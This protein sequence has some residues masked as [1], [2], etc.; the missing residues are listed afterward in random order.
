MATPELAIDYLGVH[1]QVLWN[2]RL[3]RE[4]PEVEKD[5]RRLYRKAG[6]RNL[7]RYEAVLDWLPGGG[8]RPPWYWTRLWASAIGERVAD[9]PEAV[10]ELVERME[11]DPIVKGRPF[12]FRTWRRAWSA[13]G[14]PTGCTSP[15]SLALS[16]TSRTIWAVMLASRP[17]PALGLSLSDEVTVGDLGPGST[18]R[19]QVLAPLR[20]R[21]SAK[22]AP[23][24]S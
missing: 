10:L 22:T 3:R 21:F 13:C 23:A 12:G 24:T 19:P 15:S 1:P 17:R 20:P 18:G 6:R 5:A 4:G 9:D 11:R 2:Y 8:D 14:P 7:Y 16:R